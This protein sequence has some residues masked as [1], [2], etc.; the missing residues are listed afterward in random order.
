MW[1]YNYFKKFVLEIRYGK[2]GGGAEDTFREGFSMEKIPAD[3]QLL[4]F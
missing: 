2:K 1:F 4:V 3:G